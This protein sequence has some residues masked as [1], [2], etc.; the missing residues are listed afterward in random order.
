MAGSIQLQDIVDYFRQAEW[1]I[2]HLETDSNR[3]LTTLRGRNVVMEME[4]GIN[5]EW[6][7]LQVTISLPEM[8]PS[9]RMPEALALINHVNYN[10][11]LGHFEIGIETRQISYY[12]SL[13][14]VDLPYVRSHFEALL[15]WG[16]D[17]VDEEHP[18]LM[19]VL[20]ANTPAEE[21]TLDGEQVTPPRRFDA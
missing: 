8:A 17:I 20:F 6:Q 4:V 3:V 1:P 13:P 18:R 2:D 14:I 10:L 11:P 5:Q 7:L 12:I 15:A 21:A 19:Q 16:L 9:H